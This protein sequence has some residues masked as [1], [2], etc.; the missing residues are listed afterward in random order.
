MELMPVL[1]VTSSTPWVSPCV[2]SLLLSLLL[3]RLLLLCCACRHLMLAGTQAPLWRK[4][5]SMLL[6][7]CRQAA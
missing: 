4:Q 3:M 2:Q 6:P 5:Q 7:C 1:M